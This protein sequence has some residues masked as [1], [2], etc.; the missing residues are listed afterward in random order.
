M[1]DIPITILRKTILL[2]DKDREKLNRWQ[3]H[4]IDTCWHGRMPKDRSGVNRLGLVHETV[5]VDFPDTNGLNGFVPA[6]SKT[7]VVTPDHDDVPNGIIRVR[8]LVA[9]LDLWEYRGYTIH[10]N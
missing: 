5:T 6:H 1:S 9:N 4:Y 3:L 8:T 7:F 10:Y 2:T